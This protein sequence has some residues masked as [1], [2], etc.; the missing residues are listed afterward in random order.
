MNHYKIYVF[1]V[2]LAL[3]GCANKFENYPNRVWSDFPSRTLS[4]GVA[5]GAEPL[6]I[7]GESQKYFDKDLPAEGILP[8]FILIQNQSQDRTF[9]VTPEQFA[10]RE[11]AAPIGKEDVE[12][13]GPGNNLIKTGGVLLSPAMMAIG[14]AVYW[15]AKNINSNFKRQL[16][17]T[18]TIA[19]GE[20][21]SGFVYFK[22]EQADSTHPHQWV[23]RAEPQDVKTSKSV[24]VQVVF[25]SN[26]S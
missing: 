20:S 8:V 11:A 25:Q 13:T 23:L 2:L 19:P 24:R 7:A 12:S 26:R 9:L 4:G 3:G 22:T 16:L 21:T 18:Q 5:L 17:Q 10:I 1:F 14:L 6:F 15:D